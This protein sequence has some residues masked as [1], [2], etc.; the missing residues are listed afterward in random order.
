VVTGVQLL[1]LGVVDPQVERIA[2][3]LLVSTLNSVL[4]FSN[5]CKRSKPGRLR[6]IGRIRE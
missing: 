1:A 6:T 3:D 4:R 2:V 5:A